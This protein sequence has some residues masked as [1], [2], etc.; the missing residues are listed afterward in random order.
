MP[1][2]SGPIDPCGVAL[3]ITAL[4][5]AAKRKK[6]GYTAFPYR[7]IVHS[8]FAPVRDLTQFPFWI[9][10]TVHRVLTS[11]AD[12]MAAIKAVPS[13]AFV[14][15]WFGGR[16]RF[17]KNH[18]TTEFRTGGE[19]EREKER[20]GERKGRKAEGG[21]EGERMRQQRCSA[22]FRHFDAESLERS[23]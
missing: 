10:P 22:N 3:L 19:N 15:R 21:R 1:L 9:S 13:L 4:R 20:E 6:Q 7:T 8:L 16:R 12:C 23:G 11:G 14:F 17:K 18:L 5:A 2:L